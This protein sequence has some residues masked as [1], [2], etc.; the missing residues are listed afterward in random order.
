MRWLRSLR[1]CWRRGTEAVR[2][3]GSGAAR[4][5][6]R[7]RRSPPLPIVRRLLMRAA[8]MISPSSFVHQVP[9]HQQQALRIVPECVE[10][11]LAGVA[12]TVHEVLDLVEA[13]ELHDDVRIASM[14]LTEADCRT[15]PATRSGRRRGMGSRPRP[16]GAS[17]NSRGGAVELERLGGGD[18]VNQPG[19]GR[20]AVRHEV[21]GQHIRAG[22]L[23]SPVSSAGRRVAR[24]AS[25]Q[26]W[27][28]AA[29]RAGYRRGSAAP[30]RT[31]C[32][33][34]V[35]RARAKYGFF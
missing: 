6:R 18:Q 11:V 31:S 7:G 8:F 23:R 25:R 27:G 16:V 24:R 10:L 2:F 4:Q 35:D 9:V 3:L 32:P 29:A 1:A 21:L 22:C 34:A 33:D 30:A 13:G 20:G 19:A 5:H 15:R 26:G 12:V 28:G 17:V 14:V